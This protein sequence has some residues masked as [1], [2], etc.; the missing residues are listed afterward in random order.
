MRHPFDG[1]LGVGRLQGSE[2]PQ[3]TGMTRRSVLG[4]MV[5]ATAGVLGAGAIAR[6]QGLTT[7]ALGEEGG[8]GRPTT[9]A[10][11]EEGGPGTDPGTTDTVAATTEPF[12]E[13]AGNVT[14]RAV[15]G[16]ED[17]GLPEPKPT[18][19]KGEDGGGPVTKALNEGGTSN[20]LGEEGGF[21]RAKGE[22]G[23]P[24]T[25]A[26]NEGG[27]PAPGEQ[28][29]LVKPLTLDVQ[30]KDLEKAWAEMGSDV[31]GKS[32]QACA[33]LY[34]AK[35]GFTYLK[36][37]LNI[38]VVQ[39]DEKELTAIIVKLDDNEF[40][41]REDAEA[42]LIKFGPPIQG[43]IE[44]ALKDHKSAE[45]QMRL[46]RILNKFKENN[47]LLQAEHAL[48]VLVALRTPEGKQLLKDLA[49]GDEKDWL[50]QKAKKALDRVK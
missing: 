42:K 45:M 39:P 18:E 12:G 27:G 16:L 13:E 11:G 3:G 41:A 50:A 19:A 7:Q 17:G 24:V 26:L 37:H 15:P 30:E 25:G 33:E 5:F 49:S 8:R 43:A 9:L 31:A 40:A 10:I 38:K 36:A 29:V 14:S 47:P 22:G 23:G 1:L 44:K 20:G 2:E 21:T 6:A 28:V 35:E 4:K 48:E 34:G 46:N 32:L